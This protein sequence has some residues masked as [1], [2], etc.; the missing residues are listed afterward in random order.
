MSTLMSTMAQR[1]KNDEGFTLIELMVVVMIIAVLLAIAI[2][3]FLGSQNKAK[4]RA[5]QSSLR[6]RLTAA[7]T[8]YT[9]GRTTARPRSPRSE[10]GRALAHLRRRYHGIDRRQDGLRRSRR[11]PLVHLLCRLEVRFGHV[12]LHQGRRSQSR[13]T[14]RPTPRRTPATCTAPPPPCRHRSTTA[15]GWYPTG[16]ADDHVRKGRSHG[17]PLVTANARVGP[18]YDFTLGG[19]MSILKTRLAHRRHDD[20][21]FTLIEL[22]VVVMIIAVLLAIAIPTFL[23]SQ[24]KAK[25]RSRPVVA[26]QHAHRRQDHLHR[27]RATTPRRRRW[28]HRDPRSFRAGAQLH[29]RRHRVD[30]GDGHLGQHAARVT[31]HCRH[32]VLRGSVVGLGHVLLHPRRRHSPR[33]RHRRHAVHQGHDGGELHRHLRRRAHHVHR[34]RAGDRPARRRPDQKALNEDPGS[35]A[36]FAVERPAHNSD[37]GFTIVEVLVATVVFA[38]LAT[39]FAMTLSAVAERRFGR[40]RRAPSPKERPRRSSRTPADWPMTISARSAATPPA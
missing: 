28:D 39:A 33:H 11:R 3:T 12:L 21:G 16:S 37:G 22:M 9:D 8:I 24:N 19:A 15:T 40:R 18:T 23:G 7:K 36:P 20:E 38:I 13:R 25:D 34:Q 1:R 4:D 27:R 30:K 31:G 32:D 14:A 35:D 6:N 17:D 29:R 10:G 5:A 2:P 26:A